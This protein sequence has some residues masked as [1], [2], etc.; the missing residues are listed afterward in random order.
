ML[1]FFQ[2]GPPPLMPVASQPMQVQILMQVQTSMQAKARPI[3]VGHRW[4][5]ALFLIPDRFPMPVPF[6]TQG[7]HLIL[8]KKSV[9][10]V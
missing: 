1:D 10:Q 3:Q 9:I 7:L 8:E 5:P 2:M 4:T 6:Q